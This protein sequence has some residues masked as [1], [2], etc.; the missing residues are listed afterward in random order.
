MTVLDD[1]PGIWTEGASI[2]HSVDYEWHAFIDGMAH[3]YPLV[4]LH[5]DWPPLLTPG[6]E[7]DQTFPLRHDRASVTRWQVRPVPGLT[8]PGCER[9]ALAATREALRTQGLIREAPDA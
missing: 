8:C 9:R 7:E 2:S 1:W 6:C 3:W 5:A 4:Q